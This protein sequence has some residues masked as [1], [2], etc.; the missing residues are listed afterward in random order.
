MFT[1]QRSVP[2]ALLL[3]LF[4]ACAQQDATTLSSPRLDIVE[5]NSIAGADGT[6]SAA[7]SDPVHG[8][9]HFG[10]GTIHIMPASPTGVGNCI[11]FGNNTAFGFTGFI[12][13]NVPAFSLAA[14]GKF[15]FDLGNLNN[16]PLRRD[17]YFSQANINPTLPPPGFN[18]P[19]QGV[20]ATTW[21]KVASTTQTPASPF[22][23]FVSGD[24][25]LIYTAEQPF[26]FTGGALIVGLAGSPP[27][28]FPDGGCE[29]V[30]VQ[31]TNG[32]ASG[33]FYARFFFKPHLDTGV[34]DNIVAGGSG[35][36]IGGIVIEGC[37]QPPAVSVSASPSSLWPPNHKYHK[38][39][40]AVSITD[41]CGTPSV[42]SQA[43][44]DEPDDGLGDGDTVGDVKA[45]A[46]VSSNA[47]P[48]VSFNYATDVL[49]LRAERSGT[50]D[51]RTY[52]VKVSATNA[53]G[54]G[55]GTANVS[56]PHNK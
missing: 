54:T 33:R 21:V 43:W 35:V 25:E 19:S 27:A 34:L 5:D 39:A 12:Y 47:S 2:L 3:A 29:Q 51:G 36:A 30:L 50:G 11:P 46:N 9:S 4:A 41:P 6:A 56:V 28:A 44:S 26:A 23:N 13:R 22:G 16:V 52:T 48:V 42:A 17:I 1:Q 15:A 32:D 8:S 20:K 14:G 45:G 49:E 55:S 38:I 24:Y 18:T 7:L 10:P 53:A 31:T 37:S 40:L